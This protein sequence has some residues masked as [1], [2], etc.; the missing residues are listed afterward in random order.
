MRKTK[1]AIVKSP[2]NPREKEIE[3]T[4]R[5][6]VELAGGLPDK[7]KSGA[8][9]LI[10]PN[11][12]AARPPGSG[13]TTDPRVCKA[14]ANM[15]REIGAKPIIAESSS[16]GENTEES[17]QT[18]GYGKLREEGY[19]IINL[20]EK[21]IETVKVPIPKGKS[22][23]EVTLPKIVVDA[24]VII[25]VPIMK[26]HDQAEVT[27]SLK[28]MKGVLPDTFKRKFHT[29]FG[30]FQGV[31]DLL[32]V[33]RPA[34]AVMDGIIAMEGFGP[35]FGDPVEMDLIIVGKD[36]VA[37]DAVTRE[38]MGFEPEEHGCISAATKSGVGTADLNR[39]E[40]VG[41][42]IAKVRRRF[43][44]VVEAIGD[45]PFPKGFQLI[46][47]EKACTGCRTTV[48]EF[49]LDAKNQNK[50]GELAGW[51]VVAGKIDKLP[52][53]PRERLLLVGACAAKFKDKG[54]FVE[55]CPTLCRL[56]VKA[57]GIDV[58][59]G[60]DVDAVVDVQG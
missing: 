24:D 30:V 9:V 13:A 17:I 52:D 35:I 39:I 27:L 38:V 25:S 10:K 18:A 26:T 49:L 31:A 54:I 20:K 56:I 2:K 55:G 33:V 58:V 51:T 40:V 8:T 48:T 14:I 7:V 29:T 5:K 42:P 3:T 50:L 45:I 1:I 16:I 41:E 23:K 59:S 37:V 43:K 46:V 22:V 11:I 44:R 57:M 47:D 53:V 36:L 32:T 4:V 12:V 15:V 21:G 28:N 19:E 6:A 34:L 60:I